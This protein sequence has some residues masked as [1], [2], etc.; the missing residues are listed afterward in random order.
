MLTE[1]QNPKSLNIDALSTQ[2]I[3]TVI[4]NEDKGVALAVEKVLPNIAQAVDAIVDSLRE[5][6]RLIYIGAGTSGRLGV[7]DAVECLPTYST[8]P[9]LVQ[10]L[11]AG[12]EGALIRSVE[13]AE[14]NSELGKSD[15]EA[16]E[17]TGQDIVVGIAASGRTP[18]VL[19][20]IDYAKSVGAKTIGIACNVPAPVLDTAD[21]AIGV[22]VGPEV[23]T[24]STR[25]KAGTAQKNVLNMLS[26][27]SMIKLG[28]VYGNLMVDVQVTNEKLAHR[29]QR[30]VQQ[31]EKVDNETAQ[32]LLKQ[33]NNTVKAAIVMHIKKIDYAAA[34]AL[35]E[36]HSGYLR[37]IIG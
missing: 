36:Q 35:L 2:E 37:D 19:G 1:Q 28:K 31:I 34:L 30:F 14:D 3:V 27:A 33:T 10:G 24:G 12:G 29:T 7:L 8:P 11:I 16:I 5:G 32:N 22:E 13:G 17:L 18:Y 23:V 9:E 26:T 15:L 4:N 20:A 21:I 6:G 25:M